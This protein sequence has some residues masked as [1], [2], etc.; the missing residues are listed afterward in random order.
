MHTPHKNP[1]SL[2][3][4]LTLIEVL[5]A[6]VIISFGLLG[7]AGLQ[8][9]GLKNNQSAFNRSTANILA[10]DM[11]D[12]MRANKAALI[13]GNY[14]TGGSFWDYATN[15]PAST[16]AMK[17]AD[18]KDW[19]LALQKRLPSGKGKI[20]AAASATVLRVT[21][22]WDDSR[23]TNTTGSETKSLS[24]EAQGCGTDTATACYF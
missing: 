17:D 9:T 8:L 10:Y 16:T 1:H 15:A 7:V 11:L 6:I 13:A 18:I 12:R 4:G 23:G 2:Q 24:V 21:I 5:V 3:F 22:Q 20:E 19:L 14:N